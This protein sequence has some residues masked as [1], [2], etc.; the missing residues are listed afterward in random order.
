MSGSIKRVFKAI[1]L[2]LSVAVTVAV[3]YYGYLIVEIFLAFLHTPV[4]YLLI[5]TEELSKLMQENFNDKQMH[6]MLK[7]MESSLHH[8]QRTHFGEKQEKAILDFLNGTI[9]IFQKN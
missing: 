9:K 3:I 5:K 4:E 1:A 6:Q 2:T 7:K 8:F